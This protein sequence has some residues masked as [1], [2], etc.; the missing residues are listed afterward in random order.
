MK[1]IRHFLQEQ[2][3]NNDDAETIK[4]LERILTIR[5]NRQERLESQ[6]REYRRNLADK[7]KELQTA[8]SEAQQF[9]Q[10]SIAT[11]AALREDTTGQ[12]LSVNEIFEWKHKE[13]SLTQQVEQSFEN[14]DQIEAQKHAESKKLDDHLQVYKQAVIDAEKI[15]LIKDEVA[16]KQREDA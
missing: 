8:I 10:E 11:I 13:V 15:S 3:K 2:V 14:C 12:A 6:T 4:Q 5:K 7:E 9:K 16:D 1:K